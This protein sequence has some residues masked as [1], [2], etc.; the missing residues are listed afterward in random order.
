[1]ECISY[2]KFDLP[3]FLST[4]WTKVNLQVHIIKQEVQRESSEPST[5]TI[6]IV[7]AV[8]RAEHAP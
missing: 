4:E 7:R 1:M 8:L 3:L 5:N 2:L 6:Y